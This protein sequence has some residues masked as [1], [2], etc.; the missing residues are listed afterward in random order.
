[1]VDCGSVFLFEKVPGPCGLNRLDF[2]A[3]EILRTSSTLE[4]Q[5]AT[6]RFKKVGRMDNEI[7]HAISEELPEPRACHVVCFYDMNILYT[8]GNSNVLPTKTS[9]RNV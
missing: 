7:D 9:L 1:M 6:K 2:L 5:V 4:F 3:G 8:F